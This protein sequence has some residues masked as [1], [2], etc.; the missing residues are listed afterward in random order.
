MKSA[1]IVTS[2]VMLATFTVSF[3]FSPVLLALN[4]SFLSYGLVDDFTEAD[5]KQLQ[6]E[7]LFTLNSKKPGEVHKW[8]NKETGNG[9]EI[10][11]I[12]RFKQNTNNCKRLQFKSFSNTKSST[13][14][15]NFC[16]FESAW[17]V[18]P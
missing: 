4:T 9:G 14:Y 17:K 8:S 15:Y 6:T 11:V 2:F 12:K 7:Y 1:N 16:L 13:S 10:M 3:L 18:I 5:I